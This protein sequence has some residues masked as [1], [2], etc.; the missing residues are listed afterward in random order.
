MRRAETST[1]KFRS[2]RFHAETHISAE[3]AQPIEDARLS[4]PHEDQERRGGVVASTGEGA[5]AG[6]RERRVSR[7]VIPLN[8][9]ISGAADRCLSQS[10]TE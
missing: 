8:L 7:L 1:K 10:E 3:P 9:P 5:Q 4:Q 6:V 2:Y